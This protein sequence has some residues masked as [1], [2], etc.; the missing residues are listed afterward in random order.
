MYDRR[1]S[2]PRCITKEFA[3][4]N[5]RWGRSIMDFKL[6][7]TEPWTTQSTSDPN[8]DRE[9]TDVF[10]K[11]AF[12]FYSFSFPTPIRMVCGIMNRYNRV[13]HL[14]KNEMERH[15]IHLSQ[16]EIHHG[17]KV[18]HCLLMSYP[19]DS[20]SSLKN[21]AIAILFEVGLLGSSN[22]EQL[23]DDPASALAFRT[24]D[25]RYEILTFE[26]LFSLES[27]VNAHLVQLQWFIVIGR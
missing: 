3:N 6:T 22:F 17:S 10:K 1:Q 24:T 19:P 4:K 15:F 27:R 12:F 13:E 7:L 21:V 14:K 20:D 26:R 25:S 16:N 9:T 8:L 23:P 11:V 18:A 5:L 2:I